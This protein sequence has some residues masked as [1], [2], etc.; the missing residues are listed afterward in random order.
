MNRSIQ[1]LSELKSLPVLSHE[2]PSTI[3]LHF[4]FLF[5]VFSMC[6]LPP[7]AG[8]FAKYFLMFEIMKGDSFLMIFFILLGSALS[9]FYYLKMIF[10]LI[11]YGAVSEPD[12]SKD[13]FTFD[14]GYEIL[15][16]K[17]FNK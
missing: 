17:F 2:A 15:K 7:L 5:S 9:A 14:A 1:Y 3:P 8:F 11:G 16:T 12:H 4:I 6:G 10:Q 13:K